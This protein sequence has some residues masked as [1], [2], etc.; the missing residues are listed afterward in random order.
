M[1]EESDKE[2]K[3]REGTT[4]ARLSEGQ[5]RLITEVCERTKGKLANEKEERRPTK[6]TVKGRRPVLPKKKQTRFR[7]RRYQKGFTQM[8]D[9]GRKSPA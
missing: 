1:G 7:S 5:N 3:E 8:G 6:K 4:M 9:R 2:K